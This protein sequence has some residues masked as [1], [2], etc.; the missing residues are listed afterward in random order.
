MKSSGKA[1]NLEYEDLGLDPCNSFLTLD[2]FSNLSKPQLPYLYN[3]Y[4][5]PAHDMGLSYK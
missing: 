2:N 1:L 3:G 5:I 4:I